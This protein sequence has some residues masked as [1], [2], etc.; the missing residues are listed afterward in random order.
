MIKPGGTIGILGGGQLGRMLAQAAHSLGYRT[1]VYEPKKDSCTAAVATFSTCAA[2]DNPA[3]LEEFA[4]SV[5]VITL[6]FENVPVAAVRTLEQW[7]KV[8]PN[9]DALEITQDRLKEKDLC[10]SLGIRTAPYTDINH[11][12]DLEDALTEL[13]MPAILK[14]RRL[15]YDGK[16]QYKITMLEDAAKAWQ[17]TGQNPAILEGL[18]HFTK[19]LSIIIARGTDGQTAAFPV[20]ENVHENHILSETIAPAVVSDAIQKEALKIAEKLANELNI[21]GLL[22]VEFFLTNDGKL[23]VNEMA[24][25]PH[26]SG[27]WSIEGAMTSQFE[28]AVRAVCGLPLGNAKVKYKSRMKNL[29]GKE[30]Y[31]V[32]RWLRHPSAKLH[33]YDK[34]KATEGR[35]MG[36]VT[37]LDID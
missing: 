6:E 31:D 25:R 7:C 13:G 10:Q 9:A 24:P 8:Y 16:G 32:D 23:V 5:D 30:V 17:V 4:K 18:V 28:Q 1:H 15:G 3:G 22:A 11:V 33:I 37:F 2:Y 35:K 34:G 26:N 21:V 12:D 19:E 20:V 14:T 27:H 29:L 36:H